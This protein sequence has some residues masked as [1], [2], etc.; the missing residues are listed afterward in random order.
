LLGPVSGALSASRELEYLVRAVERRRHVVFDD[1]KQAI[2]SE[3]YTESTLRLLR[4]FEVRGWR[5]QPV[6][7]NAALLLAPIANI[8]PEVID[9]CYRRVRKRSKRFAEQTPTRR[10]RLRIALKKL[11]YVI[12]FL[13]CIFDKIKVKTFVRRLKS[14]Q[15][16]L[17]HANDVRTAYD[18]LD[19]LL[20]KTDHDVCAI[21]RP[22]GIVLGWH[23]RGLADHEPKLRQHVRRLKHLNRFW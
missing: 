11:R 15:D 8:A 21:D 12:E 2:L 20:E 17:G 10:H 3:R 23:E 16:D 6:S 22:G 9:R 4:W 5:E 7:E 1:A 13:Q 14:L 19:E 18:L